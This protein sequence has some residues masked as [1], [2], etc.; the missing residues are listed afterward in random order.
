[1]QK[2]IM[3]TLADDFIMSKFVPSTDPTETHKTVLERFI[4]GKL[5]SNQMQA[6]MMSRNGKEE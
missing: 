5:G 1:M 6:A 4:S 3:K 2:V